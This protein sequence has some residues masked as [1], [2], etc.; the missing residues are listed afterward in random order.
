MYSKQFIYVRQNSPNQP[1]RAIILRSLC[2]KVLRLEKAGCD[3]CDYYELFYLL[4]PW[5]GTTTPATR[6][7]FCQPGMFMITTITCPVVSTRWNLWQCPWGSRWPVQP[8]CS[9]CLGALG[10]QPNMV[11]SPDP[12]FFVS[13]TKFS[14]FLKIFNWSSFSNNLIG[15]L[16][17]LK[18]WTVQKWFEQN[19]F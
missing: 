16:L 11:Q 10:Q 14:Y 1:K 17:V 13:G 15:T 7:G 18:L 4:I 2:S 5:H 6:T 19:I 8:R 12:P 9:R 3:Y